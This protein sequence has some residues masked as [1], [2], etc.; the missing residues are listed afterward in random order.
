MFLFYLS[1][2]FRQPFLGIKERMLVVQ[3]NNTYFLQRTRGKRGHVGQFFAQRKRLLSL[4]RKSMQQTEQTNLAERLSSHKSVENSSKINAAYK[5]LIFQKNW[6]PIDRQYAP[7]EI[8]FL[9][10]IL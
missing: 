8:L 7:L 1:N 5:Y 10:Q 6:P 3:C 9:Q 2:F 4:E